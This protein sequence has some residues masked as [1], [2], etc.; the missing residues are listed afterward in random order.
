MFKRHLLVKELLGF[1]YV[2]VGIT[3][4]T[5]ALKNSNM[6]FSFYVFPR[7]LTEC[8]NLRATF[9]KSLYSIQI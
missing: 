8:D 5:V 6:H 3:A 2:I 1:Y 9:C 4:A 7:P